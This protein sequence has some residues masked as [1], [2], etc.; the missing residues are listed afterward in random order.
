MNTKEYYRE[1]AE[2]IRLL[3][4]GRALMSDHK[5]KIEVR[6]TKKSNIVSIYINDILR[7]SIQIIKHDKFIVNKIVFRKTVESVRLDNRESLHDFI[8]ESFV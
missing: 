7:S 5:E 1:V 8:I 6:R 2:E 4:L 3:L